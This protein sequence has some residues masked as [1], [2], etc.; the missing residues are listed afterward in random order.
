MVLGQYNSVLLSIKLYWVSKG[1]V[2]LYI[3]EKVEIWSGDT[4]AS[5]THRQQNIVLLSFSPVSSLSWVTQLALPAHL[6]PCWL[7]LLVMWLSARDF[8]KGCKYLKVLEV[9]WGEELIVTLNA[10]VFSFSLSLIEPFFPRESQPCEDFR[11]WILWVYSGPYC[12]T[13]GQ[14]RCTSVICTLSATN[15]DCTLSTCREEPFRKQENGFDSWLW[16]WI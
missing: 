14:R 12:L 3:L 7:R 2:C 5:L 10:F 13:I 9:L 15:K 4:D 8:T 1:L 16:I 6:E 11:L